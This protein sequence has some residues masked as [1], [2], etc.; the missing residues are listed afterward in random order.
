MLS[1][2][3]RPWLIKT[4]VITKVVKTIPCI[5]VVFGV[6]IIASFV[7]VIV[8]SLVSTSVVFIVYGVVVVVVVVISTPTQIAEA[9]TTR[10]KCH[11][12]RERRSY[13]RAIIV[14]RL[15][16]PRETRQQRL[17]R[18]QRRETAARWPRRGGATEVVKVEKKERMNEGGK[19]SRGRIKGKRG[20]RE[21]RGGGGGGRKGGG[22]RR[23][24]DW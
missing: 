21:G 1:R 12:P 3:T 8:V 6:V 15:R 11:A 23:M 24:L 17:Q 19:K 10:R 7:V 13:A 16:L 5:E 4:I 18:R 14:A 22:S 9:E 20:R 2:I